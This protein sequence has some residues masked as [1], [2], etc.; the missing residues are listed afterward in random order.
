ML[1]NEVLIYLKTPPHYNGKVQHGL[2]NHLLVKD[3]KN[4]IYLQIHLHDL[5]NHRVS[6]SNTKLVSALMSFVVRT[7]VTAMSGKLEPMHKSRQ[8]NVLSCLL[9]YIITT[10]HIYSAHYLRDEEATHTIENH[11]RIWI[12][13]SVGLLPDHIEGG[14]VGHRSAGLSGRI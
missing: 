12:M 13:A 5:L 1:R 2:V 10:M 14:V 3:N 9:V 11:A 4:Q 7:A 6:S 8:R